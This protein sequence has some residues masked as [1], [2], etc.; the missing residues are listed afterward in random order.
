MS[1]GHVIDIT[2]PVELLTRLI[3][4]LTVLQSLPAE[5]R[6][7]IWDEE[8]SQQYIVHLYDDTL[9]HVMKW[10][11]DSN[12]AEVYLRTWIVDVLVREYKLLN[13]VDTDT[14]THALLDEE[15]SLVRRILSEV[16]DEVYSIIND[17][18]WGMWNLRK[19]DKTSLYIFNDGDYRIAT[20]HEKVAAG[21]WVS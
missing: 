14:L 12:E 4:S 1:H 19:V 15:N 11:P 7:K 16:G 20:Y 17:V 6:D 5:E 21:E 2:T 13:S 10:T 3:R 18:V 9:N 8:N